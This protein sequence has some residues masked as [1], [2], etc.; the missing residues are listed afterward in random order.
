[1]YIMILNPQGDS[2]WR[3][4]LWEVTRSCDWSPHDGTVSILRR[5]L[6]EKL[7]LLAMRGYSEEMALYNLWSRP[8]PDSESTGDSIWDVPAFRNVGNKHV[9]FKPPS[10]WYFLLEQLDQDNY[11]NNMVLSNKEKLL[12]LIF[13]KR[14]VCHIYYQQEMITILPSCAVRHCNFPGYFCM[15]LLTGVLTIKFWLYS[16]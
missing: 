8:S 7:S 6:R 14:Y 2:I 12:A 16:E 1:M 13:F 5:D 4:G 15:T 3:R 10:L 11:I 9:L